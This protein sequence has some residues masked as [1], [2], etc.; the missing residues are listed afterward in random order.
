MTIHLVY[1]SFGGENAKS[2]PAH[3]SK[4]V[5]LLSFVRAAERT[6]ETDVVFLNV[7]PIP[8]PRRELMKRVGRILSAGSTPSGMR[9]SYTFALG[10]S[11]RECWGEDDAVMFVEDDYLFTEYAFTAFADAVEHVPEAAYFTVYG[12]RPD[13]TAASERRRHAVP[14]GWHPHRDVV[15]SGRTWFNLASTTSTFGARVSALRSDLDIFKQCMRPFRRRFLD[16]ESCLIV[17]GAI[18]Y[19]GRQLLSG[20]PG[21]FAPSLRGVARAAVL[22]PYRFA[23]NQRARRQL[24][25][26]LLYAI[27]PNEGTHLEHP[28]S[29]ADRDWRAVAAEVTAWAASHPLTAA[30]G[31][32]GRTA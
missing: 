2:R 14:D 18:P 8:E 11:E 7:G 21:D 10:L 4:W 30:A 17:Q 20:L 27:T 5:T 3:Y 12:E 9:A 31:T 24:R 6:P 16:H 25:P 23:L 13:Y 26:H 32:P 29:S 19:H 28:V 22:V 1:R 15:S